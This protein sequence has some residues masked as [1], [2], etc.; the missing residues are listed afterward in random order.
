MLV[1]YLA[2]KRLSILA[3]WV[4]R[5]HRLVELIE[6]PEFTVPVSEAASRLMAFEDQED[7]TTAVKDP[8]EFMAG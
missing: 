6:A 3:F 1:L 7:E 8:S 5:W 2:Q 4:N